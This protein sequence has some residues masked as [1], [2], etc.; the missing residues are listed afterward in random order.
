MN[1]KQLKPFNES[2]AGKVAGECLENVRLGYGIAAKYLNAWAAW[3]GTDQHTGTPP[4]EVAIPCFFSWEGASNGHVGVS[5]A[6]GQ[7]WS[8]GA[9]YAS[10]A[11]FETTHT[12]VYVGWSTSI[13]GAAVV[14]A[15]TSSPTGGNTGKTLTL[16][17]NNTPFHV[18]N[19]DGPYAPADAKGELNPAKF[20]GLSYTIVA[21]KGNG[22]YVIDTEDFGQ[23]AI[24]TDG[25][26]VTI[27]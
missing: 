7:F 2:A 17:A 11:A 12:P 23:G 13:D 19:P 27:S 8:D 24:Y 9:V 16:S 10:I 15:Q 6:N 25:S 26:N 20:G 1:Y 14:E 4:S 22:I 21:D 18:Y 5:L 3:E